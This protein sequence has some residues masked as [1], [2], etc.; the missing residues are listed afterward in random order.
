MDL[1]ATCPGRGGGDWICLVLVNTAMKFWGSVS[2][3][4]FLFS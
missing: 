1:K 3:E 4:N 2:W